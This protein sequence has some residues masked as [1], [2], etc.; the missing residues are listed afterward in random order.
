MTHLNVLQNALSKLNSQLTDAKTRLASQEREIKSANS[1]LQ[2]S[3]CAT[4]NL[5][6]NFAAKEKTWEKEKLLLTQR[7]ETAET[8][9]KEIS[10]ELNGLKGRVSQMVAAIFGELSDLI[11]CVFFAKPEYKPLTDF[12]CKNLCRSLKQETE[13]RPVDQT[14]GGIY[15]H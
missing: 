5:K 7:V 13:P 3:L 9:L 10:T 8:A 1:K 14:E 6:T 4:E 12:A 2:I 15:F 11:F